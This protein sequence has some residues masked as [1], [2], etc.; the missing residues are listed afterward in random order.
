MALRMFFSLVV[1]LAFSS[2]SAI[3]GFSE[4]EEAANQTAVPDQ[5]QESSA[6]AAAVPSV[7]WVWGEVVSTDL[8]TKTILIKYTDYDTDMEKNIT[9]NFSDK[10]VF[11]GVKDLSEIK[12]KDMV[13]IDY[14]LD[15][16]GKAT[17]TNIGVEKPD[18]E[19]QAAQQPQ[20]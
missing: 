18:V 20:G 19:T 5:T 6:P 9:L 11:E 10:S 4:G 3:Q 16:A 2:L 8:Q 14:A 17:V 15:S 13:S 12:P 1:F 7:Q